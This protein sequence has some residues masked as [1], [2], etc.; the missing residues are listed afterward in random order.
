MSQLQY[1]RIR[2]KAETSGFNV[3][4]DS[5][6][7]AA[8][9]WWAASDIGLEFGAAYAAAI[10]TDISNW[11][12]LVVEVRKFTDT[13][14]SIVDITDTG[15][16]MQKTVTSFDGTLTDATWKDNSQQ[17]AAVIFSAD[18][19]NIAPGKYWLTAVVL[20][21]DSPA[22]VI[23]LCAG[24]ISVINLAYPGV[25]T[26][27]VSSDSAYT[28]TEADA[29]Y[30]QILN[31]LSEIAG[32]GSIAQAAARANLGLGGDTKWRVKS[33]GSLQL[34]NAD[35][36]LFHTIS[37]IGAAGAEQLSIGAGEA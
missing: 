7:N 35:Q 2:I 19:T 18:E 22:K 5:N 33:D 15:L 36:A 24:T 9:Q 34:W 30:L 25:G 37:V 6:N 3:P 17:H 21:T 29:R 12:Q 16:V 13:T 10:I 32:A 4:Q 11:Q 28:K 31:N 27:P 1:R 26:P 20:T 23:P 14:N 8:V